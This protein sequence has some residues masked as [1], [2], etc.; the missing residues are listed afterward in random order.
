[1]MSLNSIAEDTV[2]LGMFGQDTPCWAVGDSRAVVDGR[3][4]FDDVAA[5]N[6]DDVAL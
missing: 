4:K 2:C 1:M 6:V 3:I 5:L